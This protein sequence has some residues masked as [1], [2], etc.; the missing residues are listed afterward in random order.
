MEM[1]KHSFRVTTKGRPGLAKGIGRPNL[2]RLVTTT[3][4]EAQSGGGVNT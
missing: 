2:L 4:E 3:G 1:Q